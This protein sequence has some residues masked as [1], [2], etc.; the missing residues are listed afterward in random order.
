M[1]RFFLFFALGLL[2]ATMPSCGEGSDQSSKDSGT[3]SETTGPRRQDGLGPAEG[4]LDLSAPATL[5]C[6]F[7]FTGD[8]EAV[9][10]LD[11]RRDSWCAENHQVFD[12]R[13][14]L[15]DSKEIAHVLVYLEGLSEWASDFPPPSEPAVI[16][17]EGCRYEP[18]AL[19]LRAGQTLRVINGDDTSHNVQV[20]SKVNPET[21]FTQ[22]RLNEVDAVSFAQAEQSLP[23]LCAFH[24]WMKGWLHVF[25]HPGFA[26][27]GRDGRAVMGGIPP[28]RYRIHFWHEKLQG[29]PEPREIDL[30]PH[31][32]LDL[33][34][35][36]VAR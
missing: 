10:A 36:S 16:R 9:R 27:S 6:R 30:R 33:G 12:E 32:T 3:A 11:L 17:Q 13:L 18:H 31:E 4:R 5:T 19:A 34:R 2:A 23:L 22:H 26:L 15:S 1:K 21:N 14:V 24:P 28:G 35:L 29:L 7:F 20:L 8:A 25:D